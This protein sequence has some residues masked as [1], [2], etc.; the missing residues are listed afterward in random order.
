MRA[1]I[2]ATSDETRILVQDASGDRLLARLP[3]LTCA[4]HPRAL[5]CLVESLALWCGAKVRVVLY[6]DER[7][8]WEQSG[9]SDTFGFGL[10]TL[11]FEVEVIP[12]EPRRHRSAKRLT[13]LGSFA[14]ERSPQRRTG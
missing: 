12:V 1:T 2:T 3:S 7:F 11:F 9:L 5:P 10:D 13:G 6:V 8:S 14:R 4:G